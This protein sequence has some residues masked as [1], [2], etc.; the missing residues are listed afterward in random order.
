MK[1]DEN[2]LLPKVLTNGLFCE[3]FG[4]E[5]SILFDAIAVRCRI[6]NLG[7]ETVNISS[8]PFKILPSIALRAIHKNVKCPFFKLK[9]RMRR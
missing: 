5:S 4:A 3:R 8:S 2:S 6:L 1:H 7:K 9:C